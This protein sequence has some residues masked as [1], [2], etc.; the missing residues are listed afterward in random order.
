MPS[1]SEA[2]L[3][4]LIQDEIDE[5]YEQRLVELTS[6]PAIGGHVQYYDTAADKVYV[7]PGH[8]M[9][10]TNEIFARLDIIKSQWQDA[11]C[12]AAEYL[13]EKRRLQ[14]SS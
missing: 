10:L 6:R 2:E 11:F 14:N 9:E 13:E 5:N 3:I 12:I 1:Y 8:E 7:I 4:T